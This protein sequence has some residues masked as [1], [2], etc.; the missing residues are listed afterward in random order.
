MTAQVPERL[1]YGD[2]LLTLCTEPL[3]QYFE[4]AGVA[5]AFARSTTALWRGYVGSWEI[6]G[7]RLYMVDIS[8][9]C[10]DGTRATLDK[11]FPGFPER[12]FAHWFSGTLRLPRGRQIEYVHMGYGSVFEED[13]FLDLE[14]G[15][16]KTTRIRRNGTATT[17]NAPVASAV[18]AQAGPRR[19]K[20][21]IR[22][23]R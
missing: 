6:V 20:A 5:P 13:L 7:E 17:S 9:T 19:R 3:A 8:G 2:K 15:V 21:R 10:L 22:D 1:R 4:L 12:V 18:A 16:V 23:Q 14:R 11:I